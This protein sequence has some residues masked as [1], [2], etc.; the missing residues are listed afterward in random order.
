MGVTAMR[1]NLIKT[2][3]GRNLTQA[4]T[5]KLIGVSLRTYQRLERGERDGKQDYWE[6]L[7]RLFKKPIDDLI[8]KFPTR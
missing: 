4:N 2:R 1:K 5:A 6:S 3:T 7:K 8:K